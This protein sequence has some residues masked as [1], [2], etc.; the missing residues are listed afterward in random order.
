MEFV[1]GTIGA[2]G[3]T[4][5]LTFLKSCVNRYLF[6]PGFKIGFI[7][8]LFCDCLLTITPCCNKLSIT[9]LFPLTMGIV[10]RIP[11]TY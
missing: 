4:A 8:V 11:D 9:L 7:G 2:I 5:S 6:V 10:L 3:Y 1:S